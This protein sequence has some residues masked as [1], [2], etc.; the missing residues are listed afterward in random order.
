[1]HVNVRGTK[2]PP[3][4]TIDG[5]QVAFLPIFVSKIVQEATRPVSIPDFYPSVRKLLGIS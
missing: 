1:M 2:V 3:L 5:P 4:E